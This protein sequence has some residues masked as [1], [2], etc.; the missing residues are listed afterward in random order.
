MHSIHEL[1]DGVA[2][3]LSKKTEG[4]V[5]F[6]NLDLKTAYSQL[7]L[8]ESSKYSLVG[9]DTTGIYRF[10]TGLY[11]IGKMPN[12]FQRVKGTHAQI[13]CYIDDILVISMGTA[14]EHKSSAQKKTG[15]LRQKQHG[16]EMGE[17]RFFSRRY[18]GFNIKLQKLR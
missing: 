7:K 1:I 16:N 9:A 18:K 10:L 2:L 11:G 17:M 13:K 5:W 14:G 6:S 8:C 3:Y 4:Q 15:N 12:E